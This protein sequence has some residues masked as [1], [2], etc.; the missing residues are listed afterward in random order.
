M[1]QALVL[2]GVP[3]LSVGKTFPRVPLG[4]GNWR[5]EVEHL[6]ATVLQLTLYKRV[7]GTEG[8]EYVI[9]SVVEKDVHGHVVEGPVD[10]VVAIVT[11]GEE[12][13]INVFAVSV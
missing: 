2:G 10:L 12:S 7:I 4:P 11:P 3:R 13:S 1:R 8:G 5:V 6:V 9:P